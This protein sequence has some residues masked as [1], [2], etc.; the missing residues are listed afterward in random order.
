MNQ[1]LYALLYFLGWTIFLGV[2]VVSARAIQ[3]VLGKKKSNEFTS[4][5]K[6]GSERYWQMN[7]A[8][9][10][11]I[12]NLPVFASLV[13]IGNVAGKVDLE[14]IYAC[15]V[16]VLARVLQSTIHL[17]STTVLAVNVR[18]TFYVIQIASFVF[19]LVKLL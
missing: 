5:V 4:G 8:S 15:N 19:L 12:E 2:L 9:A 11:A 10:N 7:R 14:F 1:S 16:V 13:L 18:F 17:I 6:H 3:V